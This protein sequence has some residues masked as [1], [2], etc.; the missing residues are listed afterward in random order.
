MLKMWPNAEDVTKCWRCGLMLEVWPNAGGVALV[1]KNQL[2][3]FT[4]ALF[5]SGNKLVLVFVFIWS[6]GK[7]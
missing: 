6:G 2:Q 5:I 3:T 1:R 7:V 4:S